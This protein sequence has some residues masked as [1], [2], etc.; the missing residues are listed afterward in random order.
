MRN[1]WYPQKRAEYMTA[2]RFAELG[3]A[4]DAIG[5]RDHEFGLSLAPETG[6]GKAA[7]VE[8]HVAIHSIAVSLVPAA[9]R[10]R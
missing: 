7:D 3:L 2:T 10:E 1:V 5:L 9:R 6:E 8:P 4:R